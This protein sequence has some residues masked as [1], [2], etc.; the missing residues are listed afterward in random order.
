MNA[1]VPQKSAPPESAPQILGILQIAIPVR[2]ISR[3]T[4]FYRDVLGVKFLM[5]APNMAFFDCGGVRLYLDAGEASQNANANQ[6]VYFRSSDVHS[7]PSV[8]QAKGVSIHQ[9]PRII[10]K[11]PG[12]D[13][14]LMWIRDSE[15]NLL[16]IMEEREP[17]ASSPS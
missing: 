1:S 5:D 13:V 3:A 14:W 7:H 10:A 15:G 17:S 6:F 4:A 16:G 11:L 8:L 12:R 9:E 2:D